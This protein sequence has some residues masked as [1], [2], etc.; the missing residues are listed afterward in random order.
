MRIPKSP[1]APTRLRRIPRG[2]FSWIDRR[3]VRDGHIT[4]LPREAIALYLFLCTVADANGLSFYADPTLRKLLKLDH[5]EL[6]HA[7]NRLVR[8]DLIAYRYPLYQVLALPEMRATASCPVQRDAQAQRR[9]PTAI[10]DV[11]DVLLAQLTPP[12]RKPSS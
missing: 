6:L 12:G 5:S 2:G 1:L 7:R 4:E 3:F 11:I 8:A 9:E 10:A